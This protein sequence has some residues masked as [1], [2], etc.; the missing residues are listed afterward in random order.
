MV[1]FPPCD[2]VC[3][4]LEGHVRRFFGGR[5]V[6][7][8]TWEAGPVL[9]TN[10]HFRAAT[11]DAEHGLEFIMTVYY[12]RRGQLGLGHTCPIGEPWLPG[13][14]CDYILV[15]LPYPFGPELQECHV[16]DRHVDFLWLLPITRAEREFKLAN[17]REARER[18]FDEAGLRYCEI[19]R[20]SVV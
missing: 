15:S 13:S 16:G 5:R 2:D 14:Q 10:P 12:H 18:L 7:A 6:E 17:G 4:A 3:G 8:F 11:P 20:T 1:D 9:A 19:E